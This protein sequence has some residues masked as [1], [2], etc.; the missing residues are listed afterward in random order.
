MGYGRT[1]GLR[2]GTTFGVCLDGYANMSSR[3]RPL[4][5][6]QTDVFLLCFSVVSPPS[7]ENIR[8]KV[9]QALSNRVELIEIVVA[10]D[11]TSL[12]VSTLPRGNLLTNST[13]NTYHPRWNKVGFE[14]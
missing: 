14:G 2:V 11:P 5:Y 9:S 3:L 10:R 1:R 6:P 13:W 8:T 7:F 4:S 12:Y